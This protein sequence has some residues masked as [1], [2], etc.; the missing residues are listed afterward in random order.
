[1]ACFE[2]EQHLKTKSYYAISLVS[3][4]SPQQPSPPY[5]L[6]G[7]RG[8]QVAPPARAPLLS[9]MFTPYPFYFTIN[10]DIWT[11]NLLFSHI[12]RHPSLA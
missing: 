7:A 3:F 6:G 5:E 9:P 12:T 2:L 11:K 4:F 8:G 10:E 1:L